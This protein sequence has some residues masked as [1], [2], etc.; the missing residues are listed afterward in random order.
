[1]KFFA[2]LVSKHEKRGPRRTEDN[3]KDFIDW[4]DFNYPAF[5]PVVHYKPSEIRGS[6]ARDFVAV[7]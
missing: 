6:E 5:F 1:M 3:E 2:E 7:I 4:T